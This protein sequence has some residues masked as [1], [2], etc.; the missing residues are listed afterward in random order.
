MAKASEL[1]EQ[2][3][4]AQI[5]EELSV[6]K[7]EFQIKDASDPTR[8]VT[9]YKTDTGEPR[10]VPYWT[11]EGKNSILHNRLDDGTRAFSVTPVGNWKEGDVPCML[12]KSHP[13]REEFREIGLRSFDCVAEHLASI[14]DQRQ[15]MMHR[16][17]REWETIQA[18]EDRVRDDENREFMRIQA[19]AAQAAIDGMKKAD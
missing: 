15:H 3:E 2:A 12:A 19:R 1:L 4:V 18:H 6:P 16:H 17:G 11:L 13:R 5:V 14:Y 10:P 7:T 9:I 8:L